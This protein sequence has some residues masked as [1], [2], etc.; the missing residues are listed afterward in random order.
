MHFYRNAFT[1]VP[2]A[3]VNEVAAMLKAIRAQED[4]SASIQKAAFERH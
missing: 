4:R 1:N 2:S 3:K